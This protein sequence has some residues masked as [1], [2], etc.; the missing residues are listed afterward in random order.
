MGPTSNGREEVLRLTPEWS[1]G[2][3]E[4]PRVRGPVTG[5]SKVVPDDRRPS[6]DV[7]TEVSLHYTEGSSTVG[8]RVGRLC[9]RKVS[10]DLR[11]GPGET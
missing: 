10:S 9:G 4:Q 5:Q 6:P 7:E 8:G 2:E 3:G 1:G 11:Q